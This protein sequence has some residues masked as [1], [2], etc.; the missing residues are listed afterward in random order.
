VETLGH[1][2]TVVTVLDQ[3]RDALALIDI[4]LADRPMNVEVHTI[5]ENLARFAIG[6]GRFDL[7]PQDGVVLHGLLEY[8]P[9]RMA[10]SLLQVARSLLTDDGVVVIATVG[11]SVDR[12]LLDRLLAWPT[13]RRT[14]DGIDGLLRAARLQVVG[15]PLLEAP[16]QLVVAAPD[17]RTAIAPLGMRLR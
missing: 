15:R 17:D 7:P 10:V 13:L 3:S 12:A 1:P 6:R 16:A 2:P 4:G 11:P 5:Q 14:D 8:L 9:E